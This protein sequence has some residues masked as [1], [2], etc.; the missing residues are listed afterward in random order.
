MGTYFWLTVLLWLICAA[1]IYGFMLLGRWLSPWR[2]DKRNPYR[3][4]CKTCGTRQEYFVY[5]TYPTEIP[6]GWETVGHEYTCSRKH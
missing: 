1:I 5:N 3:R 6:I 2:Y 4:W